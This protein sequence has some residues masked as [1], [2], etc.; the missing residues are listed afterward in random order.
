MKGEKIYLRF[1][2]TED[3]DVLLEWENDPS[4][5]KSGDNKK[6]Y[7]RQEIVDFIVNGQDIRENGQMRLMICEIKG[8]E[9][10]G[11]IDLFD[12]DHYNLRAGVGVL[13]YREDKRKRG[14]ASEA[15][16]ILVDYCRKALNMKQ[17][18]CNI[19]AENKESI[20]LFRKAGFTESGLKKDWRKEGDQ[21]MDEYLFQLLLN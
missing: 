1:P 7:E 6:P 21:W 15:L 14:Y 18:Y 13:I 4:T 20:G 5:W 9:A 8:N 16:A 10:I 2:E 11:C 17:L 19:L 3:A 12:Y